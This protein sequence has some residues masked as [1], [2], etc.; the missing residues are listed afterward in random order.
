MKQ[1]LIRR[2]CEGDALEPFTF[3]KKGDT[4]LVK[5]FSNHDAFVSFEPNVSEEE[6]IKIASGYFQVCTL[7]EWGR[8]PELHGC[9]SIYV[10]ADGE[11]E[12]QLIKWKR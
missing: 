6:C 11:V 7:N 1:F 4:Y 2:E 9:H 5:N 3:E 10:K 8:D 12:V